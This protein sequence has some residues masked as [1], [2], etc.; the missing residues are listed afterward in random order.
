MSVAICVFY[1]T[2]AKVSIA[3]A[4]PSFGQRSDLLAAALSAK[5]TLRERDR[6]LVVMQ[7]YYQIALKSLMDQVYAK[8]TGKISAN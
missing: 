5:H 3:A 2:V 4:I 1:L 8:V 7:K 6:N